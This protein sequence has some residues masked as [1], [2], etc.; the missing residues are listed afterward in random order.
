MIK[1]GKLLNIRN[2]YQHPLFYKG[3]DEQTGFKTR[4]ILCFPI[5][6][7]DNI[8]GVAQLCNKVKGRSLITEKV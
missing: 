3:V 8:I 2:A 1:T 5:C 6:D 7:E 4:N